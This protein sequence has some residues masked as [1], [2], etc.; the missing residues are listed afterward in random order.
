MNKIDLH[1]HT[2]VSDG[3]DSLEE[4]I[5]KVQDAGIDLFSITDH[6][7]IKAGMLVPPMLPVADP[8][9][10]LGFIRGV[11]FSCRDEK[12]KYHI[13][14]YGYNPYIPGISEIVTEG[15]ELRMKKTKARIEFLREAYG[16][17][18]PEEEIVQL[19]NRD[20]P[21]KP[22]IANMMIKYGYANDI[23]EAMSKYINKKKFK[24]VHVR[25]EDAIE[26]I[27]K[28]GG[29]PVLAHPAYGDGDDLIMGEELDERVRYLMDYGIRGVEAFYSGFTPKIQSE[30]LELAEK[31]NLYVTAGSDYHGGNKI[32]QMGWTNLNDISEAPEG[33]TRFLSDVE[34]IHR[35]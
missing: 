32:V 1:M 9:K 5:K 28:S 27:L 14:G 6:D 22:H 31:Y 8:D 18:F 16:F 11:E 7:A 29:V 33:L 21:G 24:N 25:P 15:H 30:V 26:G 13:L 3:T 35:N 23:N 12:G 10:S 20:N 19:L 2:V 17:D 34:I 4:I